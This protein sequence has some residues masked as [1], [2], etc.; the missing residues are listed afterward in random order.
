MIKAESKDAIAKV[1]SLIEKYQL[2]AV[3]LGF[4]TGGASQADKPAKAT[5][6]GKRTAGAGKKKAASVGV[7]MYQDPKTGKTWTGRGKPPNWLAGVKDRSAF[8]INAASAAAADEPK[9]A[10]K[11]AKAAKPGKTKAT[12]ATAAPE[13]APAKASRKTASKGAVKKAM[14]RNAAATSV[15]PVKATRGAGKKAAPSK[16]AVAAVPVP[17]DAGQAAET[18]AS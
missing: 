2:T 17:A 10:T 15:K 1:R 14:A 8:L 6:G 18:P 13:K 4:M 5:R 7:A 11:S 12:K 9:K 3:D 16:K